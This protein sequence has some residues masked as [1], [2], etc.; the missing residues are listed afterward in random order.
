MAKTIGAEKA[1][2]QLPELLN[3]ASR[4]QTTIITKHGKP[5]AALG[6]VQSTRVRRHSFLALAGSGAGL[7]GDVSRF[8]AREREAWE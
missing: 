8:V 3:K 2:E 6:P 1:R 4:G 7:W 5:Y